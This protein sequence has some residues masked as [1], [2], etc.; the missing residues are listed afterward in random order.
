MHDVVILAAGGSRRLG[1]PKALLTCGGTSLMRR[2]AMLALATA[3]ARC[4]V[5]LGEQAPWL[6]VELQGLRVDTVDCLDWDAGLS[7]SLRTGFEAL[8]DSAPRVLVLG[9][10]QPALD[11]AHLA[12]LLAAAPE[13]EAA[14]SRYGGVLGMPVVVPATWRDDVLALRGDTG[15]RAVLSARAGAVVAVDAPALARDLDTPGDLAFWRAAGV[16]D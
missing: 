1:L 11:Q 8:G 16:V 7:A 15:L 3:P 2:A 5:V 14:T 12:A 4:V 13:D 9:V 6:R 10:D